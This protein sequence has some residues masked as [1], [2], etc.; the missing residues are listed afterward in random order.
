MDIDARIKAMKDKARAD[1]LEALS[2]FEALSRAGV[3]DAPTTDLAS[4]SMRPIRTMRG[5]LTQ[6]QMK[7]MR[8]DP[9]SLAALQEDSE[10]TIFIHRDGKGGHV[11]I[12]GKKD[13]SLSQ[14]DKVPESLIPTGPRKSVPQARPLDFSKPT[15]ASSLDVSEAKD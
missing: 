5:P 10:G 3:L 6:A 14:L 2:R 15:V 9:E 11:A 8:K 1:D 4:S 13:G 7:S 12:R